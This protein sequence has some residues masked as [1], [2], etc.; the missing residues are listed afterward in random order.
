[1]SGHGD[2][3]WMRTTDRETTVSQGLAWWKTGSKNRLDGV[4]TTSSGMKVGGWYLPVVFLCGNG[5]TVSHWQP[6]L[7]QLG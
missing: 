1:M 3:A 5:E 6:N 2:E 4:V 7:E